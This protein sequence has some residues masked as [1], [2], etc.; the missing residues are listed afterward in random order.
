MP[1]ENL[2]DALIAFGLP[3]AA[4][5][6]AVSL[7]KGK[8]R[9]SGSKKQVAKWKEVVEE[10]ASVAVNYPQSAYTA[11]QES[12][13]QEWQFVQRYVKDIGD[14]FTDVEKAI[15]QSFL[16]ALFGDDFDEDDPRPRLAG[17]PAKHAGMALPDHI[18]SAKSDYE[19]STLVNVHLLAALAGNENFHS[20]DRKDA[21]REVRSELKPRKKAKDDSELNSILS[22]LKCDLRRA[23]L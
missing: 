11:L 10:L 3:P 5:V 8:L 18:A 21:S 22:N 13:Q 6:L 2:T 1:Q 4:A 9:I 17:L 15:Y 12:L 23:F 19:A 20:A 7:V 16:P 14:A